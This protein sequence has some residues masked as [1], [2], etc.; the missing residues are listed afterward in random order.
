MNIEEMIKDLEYRRNKA[1]TAHREERNSEHPDIRRKE[2]AWGKIVAYGIALKYMRVVQEPLTKN[3][4][5]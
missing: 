5:L 2:S 4:T 1:L 3:K